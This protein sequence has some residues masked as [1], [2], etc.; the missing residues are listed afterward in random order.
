[1]TTNKSER[2]PKLPEWTV[3]LVAGWS[4]GAAAVLVCQPVD[5]ILTRWQAATPAVTAAV[6]GGGGVR[7]NVKDGEGV[8]VGG[9]VQISESR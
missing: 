4:S 6:S 2:K 9:S 3:D 8:V 7:V 1:M 5:T